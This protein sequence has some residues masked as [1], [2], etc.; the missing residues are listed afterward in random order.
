[1]AHQLIRGPQRDDFN[2][3][4]IVADCVTLPQGIKGSDS[5]HIEVLVKRPPYRDPRS[6][7]LVA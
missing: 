6:E 4:I 3:S 7:C 1:M 5:A 2:I